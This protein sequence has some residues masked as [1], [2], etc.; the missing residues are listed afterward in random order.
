MCFDDNVFFGYLYEKVLPFSLLHSIYTAHM[1]M[2]ITLFTAPAKRRSRVK[3]NMNGIVT[4]SFFPAI[5]FYRFVASCFCRYI[6]LLF[7]LL[8]AQSN[9]LNLGLWAFVRK[10]SLLSICRFVPRI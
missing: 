5:S 9:F 7:G 10:F 3:K 8:G 1:I 4:G 2:L 6:R